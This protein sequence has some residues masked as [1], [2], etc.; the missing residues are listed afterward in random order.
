MQVS[1]GGVVMVRGGRRVCSRRA[2][3]GGSSL[4]RRGRGLGGRRSLRNL[5]AAFD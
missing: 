1:W 4:G 5:R 3:Y 2:F